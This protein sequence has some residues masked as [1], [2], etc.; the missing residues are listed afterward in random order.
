LITIQRS[1]TALNKINLVIIVCL[2]VSV[3]FW[4]SENADLVVEYFAYSGEN[5]FKGRVWTLVTALFLHADLMHLLGNMVFLF[6][7]GNTMENEL[8]AK[9]TLSVFFVGGVL[10]SLLGT[11]FYEPSVFLIGASAAIFTLTA[12]VMLVKPLKFSFLFLMPQ[13]LV[14]IIYFTYNVLAVYYGVQ[15]NVAYISHVIGFV[16][17]VPLGIGWSKEWGK[18]LLLTGGLFLTYLLII[19]LLVPYLLQLFT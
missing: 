11:F 5:L 6:V 1:E 7:F 16:I 15:G 3:L 10:A 13:G 18:N 17:G 9:K 4:Y 8:G 12:V 2:A 19:F 14:A